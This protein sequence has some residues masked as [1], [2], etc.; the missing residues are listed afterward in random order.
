MKYRDKDY[1]YDIAKMFN[2]H[3]GIIKFFTQ[4]GLKVYGIINNA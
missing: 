1:Y 4:K 3:D 2:F